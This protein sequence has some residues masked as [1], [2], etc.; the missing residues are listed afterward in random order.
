MTL[1]I[2]CAAHTPGRPAES[3]PGENLASHA[4]N[5]GSTRSQAVPPAMPDGEDTVVGRVI[6][7]DTLELRDGR[8]VRLIGVDSPESA[9]ARY[10]VAECFGPEATAYM[11]QLLPKGT[12]VRI[13]TDIDDVDQFGRTLA[14]LYRTGD[15][16]FVNQALTANGYARALTIP[17][18]VAHVEELVASAAQA[19]QRR[20]G[21][22]SE[23]CP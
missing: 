7:G 9:T 4:T 5:P 20:V 18:N 10:G 22:W 17:P 15:G 12:D 14:Y 6:D 8:R 16:L 23:A 3:A 1:L 13:V 11:E 19:R 2:G 21:M